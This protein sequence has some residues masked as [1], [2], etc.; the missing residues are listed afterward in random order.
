MDRIYARLVS[1]FGEARLIQ[2]GCWHNT[3]VAF[4]TVGA[5]DEEVSQVRDELEADGVSEI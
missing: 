3:K 1:G 4:W 2:T 5:T